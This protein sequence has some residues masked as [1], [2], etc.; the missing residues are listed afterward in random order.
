M[1][2]D[3]IVHMRNEQPLLADL[4]FESAP[5]DTVLICRNLRATNGEKP[6]FINHIDSVFAIP[7]GH[8]RFVE[9]PDAAIEELRIER[10]ARI[11]AGQAADEP[12]GSLLD[13]LAWLDA[14]K[15]R[16]AGAAEELDGDLIRRVRDA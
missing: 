9:I 5:G 6:D 13:R 1:L 11:E 15:R 8:V 12:T 7:L 4:L 16:E 10:A 2:R 3:V 14:G